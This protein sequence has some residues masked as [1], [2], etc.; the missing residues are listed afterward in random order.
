[1]EC[2]PF[3]HLERGDGS[4]WEYCEMLTGL[5]LDCLEQAAQVS[6]ILAVDYAILLVYFILALHRRTKVHEFSYNATVTK[7]YLS[8]TSEVKIQ[9]NASNTTY[10]HTPRNEYW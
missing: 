2:I 4:G 7:I 3:R 9:H 6:G 5:Y 8:N 10:R 1:M